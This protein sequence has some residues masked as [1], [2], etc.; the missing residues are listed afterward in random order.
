[1]RHSQQAREKFLL[2]L[3][4]QL[5]PLFLQNYFIFYLFQFEGFKIQLELHVFSQVHQPL[6]QK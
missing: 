6:T 2:A 3:I 1:M 5:I 4:S